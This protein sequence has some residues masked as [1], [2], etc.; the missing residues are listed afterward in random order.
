MKIDTGNLQEK[1]DE[2]EYPILTKKRVNILKNVKYVTG[3]CLIRLDIN[4][5]E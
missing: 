3:K 5:T 2:A 4:F 1:R